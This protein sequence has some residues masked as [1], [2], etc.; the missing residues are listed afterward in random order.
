MPDYFSHYICAEKILE[1]LDKQS[2]LQI[3][4]TPLYLLGAQG[5]DIF[6]T[7]NY[8]F[9]KSNIGRKLHNMDTVELFEKLS[10][11]DKSYAAGFAAHYALDCTLHPAVYAFEAAHSFPFAHQKFENDLGLYI[12]KFYQVRRR[13]LPRESILPC[14][15]A[16]YDSIK[17][18]DPTVTVTGMERCLIRHFKYTRYLFNTKKQSYKCGFDY[19]SL[20]GAV[21]DAIELGVK[22]VKCVLSGHIEGAIFE[23]VFLQR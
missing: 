22:A 4:S 23:K 8:K 5:G 18:I 21:E 14:T 16:I 10:L 1:R 15:A 9:S 2:K 6:F 17:I 11:G 12:S 7:Y 19:T 20:T 3:T 13:I